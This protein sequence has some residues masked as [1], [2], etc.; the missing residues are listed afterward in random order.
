MGVSGK[1]GHSAARASAGDESKGHSD[2]EM[3]K[4]T[5]AKEN[6]VAELLRVH[7]ERLADKI[8]AEVATE[9]ELD[10]LQTNKLRLLL[11]NLN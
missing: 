4:F 8:K 7:D 1:P 6:A 3:A 2:Q 9:E 5:K 11:R 10:K